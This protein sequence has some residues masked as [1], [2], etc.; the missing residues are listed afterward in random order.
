MK[1]QV[2]LAG[3]GVLAVVGAAVLV[4][5]GGAE[6]G[7]SAGDPDIAAG[8]ALYG[9]Y[10][11]A[12]HGANL[13][14]QPNWREAGPDGTFPAPPHDATGHTWHHG[15]RLLFDYTRLGGQEMLRRMGAGDAKSGMPAFGDRLSDDQIRD[16]LAFIRS[17]WPERIRAAQAQRTAA[18]RQAGN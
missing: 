6:R 16:I 12:C 1:W 2:P 5:G 14:G 4:G 3:L 8:R 15:D 7:G 9:E 10:C 17:T 18:E 11:A 13:E